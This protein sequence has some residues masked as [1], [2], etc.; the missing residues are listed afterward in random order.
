V[1]DAIKLTLK[2]L[3][4]TFNMMIPIKGYICYAVPLCVNQQEKPKPKPKQRKVAKP[5]KKVA[6]KAHKRKQP[7]RKAPAKK[8]KVTL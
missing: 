8:P 6:K 7:A 4:V 1:S 3:V 5:T 2:A